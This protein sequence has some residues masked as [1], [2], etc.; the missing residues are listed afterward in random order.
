[1]GR[2]LAAALVVL[3][4]A[5]SASGAARAEAQ[6]LRS[7]PLSVTASQ[8]APLTLRLDYRLTPPGRIKSIAGRV[9]T[10]ALAA[11]RL[12]PYPAGGE[13]TEI[14]FLVD[15]SD[16]A[17]RR[18]VAENVKHIKAMLAAAKPYQRFGL[19][20]FDS[21][22]KVLVPP[23]AVPDAIEAALKQVRAVG[24][25]TYFFEAGIEAARRLGSV[26][27]AR[28]ALFIMSDGKIEDVKTART[29]D[30]LIAAAKQAGVVIFG[31]GYS[32][33][34]VEPREFQNLRVPSLET[35]GAFVKSDRRLRLPE[36]FLKDPFAAI[37]SGGRAEFDLAPLRDA[38]RGGR[39]TVRLAFTTEDGRTIEVAAT[40]TLPQ[41]GRLT[42][43]LERAQR[44]ENL[45]ATVSIVIA[46]LA[47]LTGLAL[48]GWRLVHGGRG[49]RVLSDPVAFIDFIGG[50]QA[51]VD[52]VT[53]ALRIGRSQD[54]DLALPNDSVSGYHAEIHRKR[55]GTFVIT[56]LDSKNGVFVNDES[57]KMAELHD[58]D[59]IDL[60][61]IRFR[62]TVN[63]QT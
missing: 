5:V 51:R 34:A 45:P 15:T 23:G 2:R 52:M 49:T 42:Q 18:V 20:T 38:G 3:A 6:L 14:F 4:A 11:P 24:Q 31:L 43:I 25:R 56:D 54:N 58:G 13:I 41:V 29:A 39:Q 26:A 32:R 44:R 8:P 9:A 53:A 47:G 63:R 50:A 37:D 33:S 21:E 19:A 27:A 62:F 30:D 7:G 46:V 57:V 12:T 17:R 48:E 35:G 55:D 60:G 61:E 40:V 59:E 1:V 22:L 28:R 16:P 10:T 36:E